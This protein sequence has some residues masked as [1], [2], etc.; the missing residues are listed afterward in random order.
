MR[1][2]EIGSGDNGRNVDC[3]ESCVLTADIGGISDQSDPRFPPLPFVTS[4]TDFRELSITKH[5]VGNLE[6]IFTEQE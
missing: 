5:F 3:A 6:T 4:Q 1:M 2:P